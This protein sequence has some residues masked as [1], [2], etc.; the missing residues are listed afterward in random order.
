MRGLPPGG[1]LT[2][3]RSAVEGWGR[4]GCLSHHG[5]LLEDKLVPHNMKG[6]KGH[7]PLD[8]SL[9]VAVAR[10]EA[11]QKVQHRGMVGD[12]LVEVAEGVHHALH[13]A[14]VFPHKEIPLKEL[15]ELSI[16]V[17]GSCV[18]VPEELLLES[19]PRLSAHVRLVA[20]DV[21]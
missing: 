8:K 17:E 16:E 7:D 1:R 14:A 12:R 11:T 13:L 18:P 19:E 10:A 5:E 2:A 15:V 9:Q 6:G 3:G 4:S 21:L 20:D